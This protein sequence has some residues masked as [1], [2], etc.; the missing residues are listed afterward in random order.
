[1]KISH[2]LWS[3]SFSLSCREFLPAE[4]KL[5]VCSL[6]DHANFAEFIYSSTLIKLIDCLVIDQTGARQPDDYSNNRERMMNKL[7]WWYLMNQQIL[8]CISHSFNYHFCLIQRIIFWPWKFQTVSSDHQSSDHFC[9]FFLH[10]LNAH[11]EF[12][13]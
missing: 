12:M 9:C 8:Q 11:I 4:M 5:N 3:V 13:H 7:R 1:M 6:F 2:I 10:Y